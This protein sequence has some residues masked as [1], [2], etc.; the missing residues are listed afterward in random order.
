[1][2]IAYDIQSM[3]PGC[4]IL[5][6]ALGCDSSLVHFF[7]VETWIVDSAENLKVYEIT[8]EQLVIL[9]RKTE[10]TYAKHRADSV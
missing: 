3:R 6:A 9:I 4:V 8:K 2:K 7:P 5:Q 1:M 10:E